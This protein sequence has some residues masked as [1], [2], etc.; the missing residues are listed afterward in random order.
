MKSWAFV[1]AL[2]LIILGFH[3]KRFWIFLVLAVLVMAAG[4]EK[5]PKPETH[6]AKWPAPEAPPAPIVV[7]KEITIKER[8]GKPLKITVVPK[9]EPLYKRVAETMGKTLGWGLGKIF[10]KEKK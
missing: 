5:K 6:A 8:R 7:K 2:M 1:L 10:G 9:K 3:L 4:I